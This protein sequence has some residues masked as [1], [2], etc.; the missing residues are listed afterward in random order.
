M[1]S[2]CRVI[3]P[4][5]GHA[6]VGAI[7]GRRSTGPLIRCLV[8]GGLVLAGIQGWLS[9]TAVPAATSSPAVS[10]E[11]ITGIQ[12]TLGQAALALR[13]FGQG[14]PL[15]DRFQFESGMSSVRRSVDG[16]EKTVTDPRERRALD[17]ARELLDRLADLA[18]EHIARTD[19]GGGPMAAEK[20][21]TIA[22][23]RDDAALAL[24]EF[25]QVKA[26]AVV[27]E[28]ADPLTRLV[29]GAAGAGAALLSLCVGAI[30]LW[31]RLFP[32]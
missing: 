9:F 21:Q 25:R 10:T 30:T 16:L 6:H 14:G 24:A 4:R 28:D 26:T 22:Q 23:L 31:S 8:V 20:L 19:A 1:P 2:N 7:P 5:Y 29:R 27:T 13:E 17:R 15:S 18:K 12:I 11:T 32:S 3:S